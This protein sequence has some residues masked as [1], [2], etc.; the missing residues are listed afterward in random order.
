MRGVV[1]V[2]PPCVASS[3]VGVVRAAAHRRRNPASCGSAR[4]RGRSPGGSVS[5]APARTAPRGDATARGLALGSPDPHPSWDRVSPRS[6]RD[7]TCRRHP[8]SSVA[9]RVAGHGPSI[10]A[11]ITTMPPVR[12]DDRLDASNTIWTAAL[13]CSDASGDVRCRRHSAFIGATTCSAKRR[14]GSTRSGWPKSMMRC[15]TPRSRRWPSRSTQASEAASDSGRST[16]TETALDVGRVAP[17]VAGG[18]VDD[19]THPQP[20][21]VA[22]SV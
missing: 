10:D 12:L 1:L 7:A 3:S 5:R 17:G 21:I 20:G 14:A 4:D 19:V 9:V 2:D 18:G 11:G 15:S 13:G 8:P 22:A 16:P 6:D